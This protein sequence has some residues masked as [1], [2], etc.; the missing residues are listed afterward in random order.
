MISNIQG[1]NDILLRTISTKYKNSTKFV[2][3]I[4]LSAYL[5]YFNINIWH[6]YKVGQTSIRLKIIIIVITIPFISASAFIY[7]NNIKNSLM[8]LGN[9]LKSIGL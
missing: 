4:F 5:H 7:Q 1:L 2:F 3:I 8:D 6:I 9:L